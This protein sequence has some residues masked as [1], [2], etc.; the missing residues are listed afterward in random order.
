M[1]QIPAGAFVMGCGPSCRQAV[2]VLTGADMNALGPD[3]AVYLSAY[4]IDKT[5]VRVSDFYACIRAAGCP[6]T[7]PPP[8]LA[9][10]DM[11]DPDTCNHPMTGVSWYGAS[12]YCAWAGK[13][14]CTEAEWEKAARGA[15]DRIFPWGNA[16][17]TCDLAVLNDTEETSL[18]SGGC[19]TGAVWPVGS[20]PAGAS[21]YGVLDMT[22]NATEWVHDWWADYWPSSPDDAP[23][24]TVDPEGPNSGLLRASRGSSY[25]QWQVVWGW[26]AAFARQQGEPPETLCDE[27]GFR[28]CRDAE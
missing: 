2:G 21:P 5:E 26:H 20:K 8:F 22:G 27:V 12:D 7:S 11:D 13:R 23:P 19:G 6:R 1:V 4:E 25:Y 14:L 17:P 3:H 15:D 10:W 16:L 24:P 9:Y 28:C 18:D